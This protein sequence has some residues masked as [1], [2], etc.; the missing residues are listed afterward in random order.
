MNRSSAV[1]SSSLTSLAL[2]LAFTSTVAAQDYDQCEVRRTV[3]L[4]LPGSGIQLLDITAKA[5]SLDV[6]GDPG[7]R[8]IQVE[9][10]LCA[11]DDERAEGLDVTLDRSG[12]RA[13]LETVFPENRNRGWRNGYA[14]IDLVVS[15]PA[16]MD[17]RIVDGSGHAN[18][19]GTGDLNI[20][21]GSGH[22]EL[23]EIG[24]ELNV[25]DGSGHVEIYDVA[26]GIHLEDGS[27]TITIS[28]VEGSVTLDDGSG[29][30]E[31]EDV[32]ENVTVT[33][34]GSG[35]IEVRDVAGDLSVSGTRRE[36]IRYDNISGTLD[37]PEP[38]RRGRG[39]NR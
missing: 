9:A 35:R 39:G 4:D 6:V 29:N 14:K 13:V 28:G 36:R 2:A 18:V 15:M 7:V 10:T 25:E 21:D 26:G 20:D 12:S 33:D 17:T 32:R 16:G 22:L 24:G 11:S 8:G 31:I 3:E 34:K 5:G 30:V 19:S 37:L 1:L 27:G 38:R 23:H